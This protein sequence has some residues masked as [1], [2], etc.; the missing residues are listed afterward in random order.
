MTAS[1]KPNEQYK[2]NNPYDEGQKKLEVSSFSWENL[3]DAILDTVAIIR[4]SV[5]RSISIISSTSQCVIARLSL[6]S[7]AILLR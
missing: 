2:R 7:Q 4:N 1:P 6:T 3:F 5:T